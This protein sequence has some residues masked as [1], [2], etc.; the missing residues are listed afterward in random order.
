[1]ADP[2]DDGALDDG[3]LDDGALDGD[4]LLFAD[5][6]PPDIAAARAARAVKP[7]KILIVDDDTEVHAITR[8]VLGDV[9]FDDRPLRFLS[10]HSGAEARA[11]L[12]EHDDIAAVLL[13]VV[14]ETDDA[15]LKLVRF[16]REEMGNRQVRIILRTGQPGQAPERQVIVAYDINDYKAKS[17]LTAQK[18]FTTTVAALRSFQHISTIDQSRRGLETVVQA[19]DTLF[20]QR[21]LPGLAEGIVRQ[22]AGLLPELDGAILC[23]LPGESAEAEILAG[24]GRFAD[25]AGRPVDGAVEAGVAADVATA[26][27]DGASV[28]GGRHSVIALRGRDHAASALCLCGH[29]PLSDMDRRMVE[30]FCKKA[31][32]SFDN[33]F[34]YEQLRLA[35]LATVHALGKLA[36]YKDEV[37]GDHVKRIGRW[38]TAIARELQG[39]GS[40]P[41]LVDDR[42]C[43]LIGMA[44][45]LHD[46]GKVGIPDSILRKPGKLDAEE[47]R[48]MREHAAMG[49]RILRDASGL[50]GGRSYLTLGAEIAESHHEKFDGTGYPGGLAGDA[51]PL[52][53]RIVAVADVYDAL[54]HRRPYKEAWEL[55]AVLELIRGESGKHFDPRVVDAFVTVLERE[56]VLAVSQ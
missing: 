2:L 13:D 11:I 55:T 23:A 29:E 8:V 15:G 24:S 44:S 34:L 31:A 9:R 4:D 18:L 38:A 17:E 19:A 14:M 5:E 20:K 48:Q 1:M 40:F 47:M 35:Q 25:M 49:G 26:L 27:R 42:F 52:S 3:A 16:I 33:V 10:A 56:G 43:E 39:R 28:F 54:L 22:A 50:V 6:D 37:T 21:S 45:M 41:G 46:V 32:I 36:E 30:I 53:G 51:I 7:W 12:H